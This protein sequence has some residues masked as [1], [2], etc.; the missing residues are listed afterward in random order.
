MGRVVEGLADLDGS[1]P[2]TMLGLCRS[3]GHL[4]S[5]YAAGRRVIYVNPFKYA[6]AMVALFFLAH[7]LL[8]IDPSGGYGGRVDPTLDPRIAARLAAA[9][10]SIQAHLNV[11]MFLALPPFALALMGLFRRSGRNFAETYAFTLFTSGQ[12]SLF[13]VLLLPL[14]FV[15]QPGGTWIRIV[16]HFA[17]MIWAAAGFF[18][19]PGRVVGALKVLLASAVYTLV[20]VI[21]AAVLMVVSM[22]TAPR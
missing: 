13:G 11:L 18:P 1:W 21:L 19:Q 9:Q 8:G 22:L 15:S 7:G 20:L 17:Y 3:P 10:A 16:M 2:R 5:E 12:T 4:C 6:L 14:D